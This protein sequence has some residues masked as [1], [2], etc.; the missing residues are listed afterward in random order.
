MLNL[1]AAIW[2]L[3]CACL[4]GI[5][6]PR[7]AVAEV[8]GTG[9]FLAMAERDAQIAVVEAALARTEVQ[10]QLER[11]GVGIDQALERVAALSQAELAALA[12][13]IEEMPAGSGAL[14]VIGVVF[15]VLVILEVVGV[16]DVF[17]GI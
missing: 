7:H 15:L 9:E 8:I 6:V 13:N 2:G 16:I 17:K 12:G 10:S 14:A 11:L 3:A 5:G 4:L 1:R